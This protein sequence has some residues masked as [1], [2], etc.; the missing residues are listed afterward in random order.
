M[1]KIMQLLEPKNIHKSYLILSLTIGTIFSLFMPLFN[2]P[3]GQYHLAVS[4]KVV[5]TIIDTSRYGEPKIDSGMTRQGSSFK[6][7]TRF[8]KYY[9]NKAVF[10]SDKEMPRD[11]RYSLLDFT[12][13]GHL[14]PAIGL[15]IGKFIY[16]S[17]GV[18]ITVA[19]LLSVLINSIFLYLII[20]YLKF[21]KLLYF[22]IFLSPVAMN[23]FASLSYDTTGFVTVAFLMM[24]VF[25]T[26]EDKKISK[27]TRYMFGL[28]ATFILLGAKW[29]YWLLIVLWPILELTYTNYFASFRK[30]ILLSVERI[31]SK[32]RNIFLFCLFLL[33]FGLVVAIILTRNHGGLFLVVQRY[34]MTFGYN[35]AGMNLL[36]NDITSWLAAPYPSQNYIPTWISAVWYLMIFLVLFSEKKFVKNKFLGYLALSLFFIGVF[37]VYYTMLD[38]NGARTSY[39][40]GVQGRYFTPTLLLIQLFASSTMPRLNR[41]A[42]Q[43]IP[44]YISLLVIVSNI[45]LLFDTVVGLLM[46]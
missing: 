33:F 46:R 37:G 4:G 42:R 12:F 44:I 2:E 5:N 31:T 13:W 18:M 9:L 1:K 38:Y 39:I 45:L 30:F 16:P 6:N 10:I 17:I 32:K 23:S 41:P 21:G 8:E 40:E 11:V 14:I 29:N 3:D 35:Y 22:S 15:L 20:K 24:L 27:K 19:R 25:N 28:A 43:L 36:S 26:L 7:G 34:L